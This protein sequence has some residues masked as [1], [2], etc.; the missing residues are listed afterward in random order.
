MLERR[1]RQHLGQRFA[2]V[3]AGHQQGRRALFGRGLEIQ[4]V[5]RLAQPATVEPA[6]QGGQRAG[7][8]RVLREAGGLDRG[9]V[10]QRFQHLRVVAVGIAGDRLARPGIGQQQRFQRGAVDRRL[11]RRRHQLRPLDRVAGEVG[12][13]RGIV[14][15]V[16][17]VLALL[18]LVQRR[19]A[20][21]DVAALDQLRHLPV[22]ESQQQGADVAAVDVGV[23]HQDDAVVAQLVRVVLVLADAGAQRGD[24]RADLGAGQHAVEARALDVEDLALQRQDRLGLAVAA[25]L[26]RA[27]RRV[28]LDDEQLGQR[29]I[30]LLAV[31]ELAGQAGDVQRALAAGQVAG[32]AGGFARTRSVHDLARDGLRFVGMFLEELLQTCGERAVNNRSH[33]G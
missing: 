17:L 11:S 10:D 32:L 15:Q 29:R 2:H 7:R 4:R 24:Q 20:D 21:V 19:Q 6:G 3:Q 30:L 5:A 27:A 16:Q 23:G 31:G 14:L 1:H 12:I 33:V 25:L 13:Q 8:V 26:G 9:E 28:A 22:E 18:D